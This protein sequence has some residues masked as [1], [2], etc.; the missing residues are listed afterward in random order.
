MRPNWNW[1]FLGLGVLGLLISFAEPIRR[2]LAIQIG[3]LAGAILAGVVIAL[4]CAMFSL[5]AVG[6]APGTI[7]HPLW[8][9]M[10]AAVLGAI[11]FGAEA[12]LIYVYTHHPSPTESRTP[13][14]WDFTNV[15]SASGA[16]SYTHLTLPTIYSV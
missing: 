15:L 7:H 8:S 3:Q 10:G 4:A 14:A 6:L 12:R 2:Y 16:V 5:F 11:L 13:M 1:L 9:V